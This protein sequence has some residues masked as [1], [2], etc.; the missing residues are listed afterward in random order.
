MLK[1][2]ICDDNKAFVKHFKSLIT[3]VIKEYKN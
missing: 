1:I 2:A 3:E